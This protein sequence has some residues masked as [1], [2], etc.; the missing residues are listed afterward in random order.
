MTFS[1]SSRTRVPDYV[2]RRPAED[3]IVLLNLETKQSYGLDVVGT[4]MLDALSESGSIGVAR[5]LLLSE[6]DVEPEQLTR[7]LMH[8][9]EQLIKWKL[10]EIL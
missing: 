2:L 9:I 4:R 7:D 1:F 3:G 10:L 5:E 6:F 8:L